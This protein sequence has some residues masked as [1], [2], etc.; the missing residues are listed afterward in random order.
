MTMRDL[1]MVAA[2]WAGAASAEVPTV[3][4]AGRNFISRA[5]ILA[6]EARSVVRDQATPGATV[7]TPL[8][9]Q[10][11]L[12]AHMEYR[13]GA[14]SDYHAHKDEAELFVVIDGGGVMAIGGTLVNPRDDGHD[15]HAAIADGATIRRLAAGDMILIPAGTSH[16][17]RS[18]DGHLTMV[19]MHLSPPPAR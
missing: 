16:S 2:C 10:G 14:S 15:L 6:V 9:E 17:V 1:I 19:A 18:V 11:T 4:A 13:T 3:D 5:D 8:M 7:L 12:N